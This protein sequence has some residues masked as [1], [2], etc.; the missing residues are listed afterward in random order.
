MSRTGR[1]FGFL[2]F[3]DV[4]NVTQL[5]HRLNQ[6][7]IGS[8]KL[9][10]NIA[11]YSR[12]FKEDR[13][14]RQK[15]PEPSHVNRGG[16]RSGPSRSYADVVREHR[17][18]AEDGS[19]MMHQRVR[20]TNVG[21]CSKGVL[22]LVS[23]KEDNAWLIGSYI[24][25]VHPSVDIFCLHTQLPCLHNFGCELHFLGGREVLIS[26]ADEEGVV[27]FLAEVNSRDPQY[28][29][30]ARLWNPSEVCLGRT[31]WLRCYGLPFHIWTGIC[32]KQIAEAW[33]DFISIDSRTET[34]RC[35]LFARIAVHTKRQ[36]RIDEN[37]TIKVDGASFTIRVYEEM[38]SCEDCYHR[39]AAELVGYSKLHQTPSR[40]VSPSLSFVEE[41]N[42]LLRRDSPVKVSPGL[43][44]GPT[45]LQH[46]TDSSQGL[47]NRGP[48]KVDGDRCQSAAEANSR[49]H[50]FKEA[51]VFTENF[52]ERGG[53]P[54]LGPSG[55]RCGDYMG[56]SAGLHSQEV[57]GSLKAF[58]PPG[59][60]CGDHVG[61]SVNRT[62][63]SP[64]PEAF[65]ASVQAGSHLQ[66][67]TGSLKA[68]GPSSC[69]AQPQPTHASVGLGDIP[70]S[71]FGVGLGV[72]P[73]RPVVS[74]TDCGRMKV[75]S[76]RSSKKKSM[77]AILALGSQKTRAIMQRT[78]K[79]QKA[80][81]SKLYKKKQGQLVESERERDTVGVSGETVS[82]SQIL[83][84]NR[85]L[86]DLNEEQQ[87]QNPGGFL[88]SSQV[89]DFL[90]QIGV[91]HRNAE[92]VIQHLEALE[93]R[94]KSG[95]KEANPAPHAGQS[96]EE[97]IHK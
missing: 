34:R 14:E 69:A 74:G 54:H 61:L 72:S 91:T 1:R 55:E 35:L 24:V 58:G 29:T 92:E 52:S 89:W 32:F 21:E 80:V 68:Y 70:P 43:G 76:L 53:F 15:T 64:S 25:E 66:E 37:V 13:K 85:I 97:D 41:T 83:N 12:M 3:L 60:R 10:A 23:R 94:D 86:C 77:D 50:I 27:R 81:R 20:N 8:Y 46:V 4:T 88:N 45:P 96:K 93:R 22:E 82:D 42:S 6:V 33:G 9:R 16:P 19:R 95:F 31:V 36:A 62:K 39:D 49:D 57:T 65:S 17:G 5:E 73:C 44:V 28:F 40:M 59:E 30:S 18:S 11:R 78:L 90:T 26:S 75:K 87:Q 51:G 56:L 71:G 67:M 38:E 84:R 7:W 48:V 47:R 2:R 79:K 63:C